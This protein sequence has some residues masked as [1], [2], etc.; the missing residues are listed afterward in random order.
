MNIADFSSK[1]DSY[2]DSISSD[3]MNKLSDIDAASKIL[4]ATILAVD[5]KFVHVD[6]GLK[7]EG[8]V[9]LHEFSI[10]GVLPELKVGGK[11]QV[12]RESASDGQSIS[13]SHTRA[14]KELA[15]S[16]LEKL[17]N[18][19]KTAE[20]VVVSHAKG[21]YVVEIFGAPVFL[22]AKQLDIQGDIIGKNLELRIVRMDRSNMS[23][24][25]ARKQAIESD[26]ECMVQIGEIVTAIITAVSEDMLILEYKNIK[27]NMS[28]KDYLYDY[29]DDLRSEFSV[30]QSLRVKIINIDKT[31]IKVGHKQ[32]LTDPWIESIQYAGVSVGAMLEATVDKIQNSGVQ[33]LLDTKPVLSAY[34][35][36]DEISW[37][38]KPVSL[39]DAVKLDQKYTVYITNIDKK[40]KIMFVS[41]RKCNPNPLVQFAQKN[42][43]GDTIEGTVKDVTPFGTIIK[44]KH[45]AEGIAQNVALEIGTHVKATITAIEPM[46]NILSVSVTEES[47]KKFDA[48][49]HVQLNTIMKFKVAQITEYTVMLVNENGLQACIKRNELDAYEYK[50]DALVYVTVLEKDAKQKML[51]VGNQMDV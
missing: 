48:F 22:P 24:T 7:Q 4:E 35:P 20:G 36:A 21:G 9:S 19:K 44:F 16:K 1:L 28:A 25:A 30:G 32:L 31:T 38:K 3:W 14:R 50:Q 11:V 27:L 15:W 46:K 10:N 37:S 29:T 18:T 45:D 2:M 49:D 47:D 5:G 39:V 13:F 26:D 33:L 12:Y 6:A 17:Y 43:V 34:L 40:R 8:K 23:I 51:I 42:N 41:L